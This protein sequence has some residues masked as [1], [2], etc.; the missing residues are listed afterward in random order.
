M[1]LTE[2]AQGY[3]LRGLTI[4]HEYYG[5]W[6][7]RH[8]ELRKQIVEEINPLLTQYGAELI[9]VNLVPDPDEDEDADPVHQFS[10]SCNCPDCLEERLQ[11]DCP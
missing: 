11:Q 10:R 9:D 5:N 4:I 2:L 6:E 7:E 8:R 3:V 1:T